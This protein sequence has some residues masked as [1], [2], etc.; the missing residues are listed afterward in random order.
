[1]SRLLRFSNHHPVISMLVGWLLLI[2]ISMVILP[3][4]PP[5]V[6][7]AMHRSAT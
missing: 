4:D 6:D 3:P 1:M 5:S 7:A 2:A